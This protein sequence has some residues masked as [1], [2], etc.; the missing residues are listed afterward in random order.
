MGRTRRTGFKNKRVSV[1]VRQSSSAQTGQGGNPISI[2]ASDVGVV[3][4]DVKNK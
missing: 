4:T 2:N 3:R 1:V